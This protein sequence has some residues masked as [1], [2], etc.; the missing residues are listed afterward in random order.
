MK[1]LFPKDVFV[2]QDGNEASRNKGYWSLAAIAGCGV[3]ILAIVLCQVQIANTI[4]PGIS[5]Y[6]QGDY[7]AAESD[8]RK[9][10]HDA[11]TA[12]DPEGH[13]YL[14]LCLLHEGKFGEGR[15]EI[16]WTRDH[17]GN[18]SK[19]INARAEWL[20]KSLDKLPAS[21]TAAQTQQWQLKYLT[22]HHGH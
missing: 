18:K 21:P 15:T 8:F 2:E 22:Q 20:L 13:Y 11:M 6:N 10:T 17:S 9:Y 4:K 5:H 14:G 16:K 3:L 7:T 12:E 1:E 19:G